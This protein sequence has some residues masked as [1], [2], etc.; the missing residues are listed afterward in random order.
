MSDILG[1]IGENKTN[2]NMNNNESS[3][4]IVDKTVFFY[5]IS[6]KMYDT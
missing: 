6:V 3:G 1:D 2:T 5:L 4:N